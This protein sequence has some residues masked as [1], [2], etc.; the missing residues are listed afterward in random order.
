MCTPVLT[1]VSFYMLKMPGMGRRCVERAGE[2]SRCD[3]EQ[4]GRGLSVQNSPAR[5]VECASRVCLWDQQCHPIADCTR[6]ASHVELYIFCIRYQTK[7]QPT[8]T[9]ALMI[10]P[11]GQYNPQAFAAMDYIIA[12]VIPQHDCILS[13]TSL[14]T[15]CAE[16]S[17]KCGDAG[18]CL[19]CEADARA[20]GQLEV[21]G[22]QA[23]G[24]PQ[25]LS[26]IL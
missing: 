20:C 21:C 13:S 9:D 5:R 1:K 2:C 18:G 14:G 16:R 4:A 8:L 15:H 17:I 7:H 24:A 6:Q 22:E 3:R 11:A 23:A 10:C 12:L 25:Q 19:Q 26:S